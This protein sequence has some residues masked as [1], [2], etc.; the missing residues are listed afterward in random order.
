MRFSV[1]AA[2]AETP[3]RIAWLID[4]EA[5][6]FATLALATQR[7][8]GWLKDEG[9]L[10]AERVALVG[11]LDFPTMVTLMALFEARVPV[12][13]L[14]PR[15]TRAE[16]QRFV[17]RCGPAM[18]LSS[19][20]CPSAGDRSQVPDSWPT[21]PGRAAVADD[22]LPLVVLA[23]SG[24]AGA[25][26]G[27][28]LSR[29]AFIASAD[30]SAA[31]L[32]WRSEDRWLLALPP[33]HVGGL[34]ILTRC[35]LGR[36]TVVVETASGFDAAS[37]IKT[38]EQRRVTLLSLVPAMLRR[39]LDQAPAWQPPPHLR[40]VLLGGAAASPALCAAARARGWP[41]VTTYG[42]TEACSQVATQRPMDQAGTSLD[43]DDCGLP[44]PGM[45]VR[46]AE[47]GVIEV[48]GPSLMTRYL[49]ATTEQPFTADGW[50]RTGDRGRLDA[51]GRVHILGRA[52]DL[53]VTGGENVDPL[54][55]EQA[56][57]THPAIRA[58]CVFGVDSPAWGQAVA[59]AVVL[60]G[61]RPRDTDLS[62]HLRGCLAGFKVPRFLTVVD[63]FA[64]TAAGK[65][66]R[67]ATA[68]AA[69]DLR[70]LD[71]G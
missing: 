18:M 21:T 59:A 57:E 51:L 60:D 9:A 50:L 5:T 56:L 27:V 30:A 23:T 33:A 45:R 48:G 64:I 25:P 35:L 34:S 66:D 67:R 69:M 31:V 24:T 44:L 7:A 12:V 65:R 58:A 14:H 36:R 68:A 55:V 13:L 20:W 63:G 39:V 38:I 1:R 29:R 6:S 26:K 15:W 71:R 54:E 32:G 61:P 10:D 43:G 62:A 17:A 52:D 46:V 11:T 70:P 4:G 40:A 53:I 16:R 8:L 42:L 22:D 28:E 3:E 2:A 37:L 19:P 49:P 47:D 41:L